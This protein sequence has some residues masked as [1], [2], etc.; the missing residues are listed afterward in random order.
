MPANRFAF[1]NGAI[2]PIEE[3]QISVMT[4]TFNYGTGCFEGIRGYWVPEQEQLYVFQLRAHMERLHRS[5][6]I[7]YM[8]LAYSVD[9]LCDLAV[10]LLR[11]EGFREDVYI[12]PLV[13]KSDPAIAVQMNGLTDAFTMFA[14]GFGQYMAGDSV[15]ACVS[16]WRRIDDNIIPSRAK[17][18]GAYINSALAKT[19][20]LL[21]GYDE[22]IVL[23][24]DGQVSEASAANLF[25]VRDGKLITPPLYSDVLEGIT[26]QVVV[27]LARE[28]LGVPVIERAIDRTELYVADEAFFCGTGAELKPIV[29][30]DHR[31]VGDGKVGPIAGLL[32]RL[33][34]DLVRARL[35]AYRRWCTP[36]YA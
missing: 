10:E 21:N 28:H 32:V 9:E 33:Y 11:R 8:K 18:C 15:R 12:R 23:G 34:A 1:F 16:S 24:S 2:V 25:I 29:E 31:T 4:N 14:L 13:Y 6:R 20:A 3:A 22:A 17:A 5:S 19:E 30:I 35:S 26:R 27:E 36:I 7:L